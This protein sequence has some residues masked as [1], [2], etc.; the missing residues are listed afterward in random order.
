MT[1]YYD[2]AEGV[3]ITRRRALRELAD[4][5]IVDPDRI[6]EFLEACGDLREYNAQDVLDWLGY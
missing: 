1:T 6:G 3:T 4:H 5:G 2:T